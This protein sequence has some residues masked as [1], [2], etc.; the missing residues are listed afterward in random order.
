MQLRST[1]GWMNT[2][3]ISLVTDTHTHTQVFWHDDQI[4]VDNTSRLR[5]TQSVLWHF[6]QADQSLNSCFTVL[7]FFCLRR[8]CCHGKKKKKKKSTRSSSVWGNQS[9]SRRSR[10]TSLVQQQT[11]TVHTWPK[12]ARGG[13]RPC[14]RRCPINVDSVE[15]FPRDGDGNTFL[16]VG[17]S[18]SP[19]PLL[20]SH[21]TP[22]T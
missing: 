7:F 13:R 3:A 14:F 8:L 10:L 17:A 5:T 4:K 20:P 19:L 9:S 6:Y 21:T 2:L 16:K 1:L 15:M 22:K 18:S 11:T 12:H